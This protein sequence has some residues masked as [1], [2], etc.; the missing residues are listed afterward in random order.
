[1]NYYIEFI[2]L[3]DCFQP[4]WVVSLSKNEDVK[5]IAARSVSLRYA[6]ELWGYDSAPELL[7]NKL[8]KLSPGFIQPFSSPD[9]SFKIKVET[10]CNSQTQ[11]EKIR[12][13]EVE[14]LVFIHF[15]C[16]NFIFKKD[17]NASIKFLL[18]LSSV[19]NYL[20]AYY[21]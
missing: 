18:L 16:L 3:F 5:K 17:K 21:C 11:D 13:I 7:H 1:M 2:L 9:K 6:I 10:F 19:Y 14:I 12:K 15:S 8:K 20:S 4:W